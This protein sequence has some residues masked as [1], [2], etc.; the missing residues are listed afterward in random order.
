MKIKS[1]ERKGRMAVIHFFE[2]ESI[3]VNPN[4]VYDFSLRKNDEISIDKFNQIL[5][6]QDFIRVQNSAM[7]S[8]SRRDHSVFELKQKLIT[9][10]Y[11]PKNVEIVIDK[12][13]K[14]DLLNDLKFAKKYIESCRV[15]K[16]IGDIKI[17]NDLLKKRV[18]SEIIDNLMNDEKDVELEK[19]NLYDLISKKMRLL[20]NKNLDENKVRERVYRFLIN[21]GFNYSQV[22]SAFDLYLNENES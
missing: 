21:K 13:L 16:K 17:R 7:W 4:I 12:L 5:Q 11:D 19:R 6:K 8:L 14:L 2:E 18:S 22:K 10:Q 1:I 3:K 9:K 20:E 15:N